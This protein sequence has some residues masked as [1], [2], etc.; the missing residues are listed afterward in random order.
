M[1][2]TYHPKLGD[3]NQYSCG[4]SETIFELLAWKSTNIIVQYDTPSGPHGHR[5]DSDSL[6]NSTNQDS[7]LPSLSHN[8]DVSE[9]TATHPSGNSPPRREQDSHLGSFI[10]TDGAQMKNRVGVLI[11]A[12]HPGRDGSTE[13]SNS[14]ETFASGSSYVREMDIQT[15]GEIAQQVSSSSVVIVRL[16]FPPVSSNTPSISEREAERERS[17]RQQCGIQ[18][19]PTERETVIQMMT[20][21]ESESPKQPSSTG[22]ERV[23]DSEERE[24]VTQKKNEPHLVYTQS[25]NIEEFLQG[26]NGDEDEVVRGFAER[27]VRRPEKLLTT[28][29]TLQVS[30]LS[31]GSAT[32]TSSGPS[33]GCYLEQWPTAEH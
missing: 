3:H 22:I 29:S 2:P 16:P 25:N 21:S 15:S 20:D 24:G 23:L 11:S 9:T 30:D 19:S 8:E 31:S 28:H 17:N 13:S 6:S 1:D 10:S 27:F 14:G 33:T 18:H 26:Q 5:G 32:T 7:S 4:S 12:H